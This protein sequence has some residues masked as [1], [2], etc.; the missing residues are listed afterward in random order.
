MVRV[1]A[2]HAQGRQ[3]AVLKCHTKEKKQHNWSQWT[4]QLLEKHEE[5]AKNSQ[6]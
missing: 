5:K 4:N 1:L 3:Q 6:P 2:N